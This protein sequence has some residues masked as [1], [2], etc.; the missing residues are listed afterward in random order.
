QQR[1]REFN[2]HNRLAQPAPSA[3]AAS[4]PFFQR[5]QAVRSRGLKRR[6]E[7]KDDA[8]QQSRQQREAQRSPVNVHILQ[9]RQTVRS[10]FRHQIDPPHR[11]QS[12]RRASA[13]RQQ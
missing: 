4:R 10:I 3:R 1:Q 2:D 5:R 13:E 7:A 11:Q 6:R 12:P 9:S 8:S